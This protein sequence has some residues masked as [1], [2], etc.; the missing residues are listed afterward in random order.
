MVVKELFSDFQ[1]DTKVST[2]NFMG[3]SLLRKMII[4]LLKLDIS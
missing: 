4:L 3:L 1:E 2:G